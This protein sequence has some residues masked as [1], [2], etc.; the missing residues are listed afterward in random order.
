MGDEVWVLNLMDNPLQLHWFRKDN[1]T[2]N[3]VIQEENVEVLCNRETPMSWAT[4]YFSDGSGWVIKN[5]ESIIQIDADGNIN[6]SRPE[7]H[8]AI[9]ITEDG[10]GIGGTEH[11]AVY[12]DTLVEVLR[13]IQQTL[14]LIQ[15][16]SMSN[17]FTNPIS[18]AIGSAPTQL[19]TLIP[20][21]TSPHVSLD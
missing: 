5:D 3:P 14:Q 6:I 17:V 21:I 8:R 7:A 16:A 11:P 12:G 18:I 4:I 15:S 19:A 13:N 9:S 20:K 1:F 2:E 10:I